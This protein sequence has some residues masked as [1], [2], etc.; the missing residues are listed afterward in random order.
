ML[1]DMLFKRQ[2]SLT[3]Y[4]NKKLMLGEMSF[5]KDFITDTRGDLYPLLCKEGEPTETISGGFYHVTGSETDFLSRLV[6]QFFP[7]ANYEL[8]LEALEGTVGFQFLKPDGSCFMCTLSGKNGTLYNDNQPVCALVP[9]LSLIFSCR[10]AYIDLYTKAPDGVPTFLHTTFAPGFDD[11]CRESVFSGSYAAL[12]VSGTAV[13]RSVSF[14]MDCGLSQADMRPIRY[15]NGEIMLENGKVFLSMSIRQQ[16]GGYQGIFSWIPGTSEFELCGALFYDAGDGL[17]ANDVAL[18]M[19]YHRTEKKWMYWVCSFAHE[20]ILAHG[21]CTGEVRYGVH[22]LDVTLMP[23][24][25]ATDPDT[26]FLAKQDDEDPDFVYDEASGRWYM[27]ICRLVED[28]KGRGYRYFL[29]SSERPFDGYVPVSHASEGEETGGSFVRDGQ[30]LAFACG[31]G[32]GRRAEYRVYRVPDF[33]SYTLLAHEYDDG[34]FRGWGTVMPIPVGSRT[35]WYHLTFDRANA[36][37]YNW[38]YGNLYCFRGTSVF[39]K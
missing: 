20:H 14:Y 24:K 18:S 2:F 13:L 26:V 23:K 30:G 10:G 38:S 27:S 36:S 22:V 34:G 32:F 33:S 29:F 17:W 15:E 37:S 5:F 25:K 28:E 19:L 39:S 21:E 35:E 3:L 6:G 7:Y 1:S 16:E 11:L 4:K 8:Q 31:N 12:A 9:G